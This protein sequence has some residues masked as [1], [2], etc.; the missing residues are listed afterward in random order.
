LP[1]LR[2]PKGAQADAI[3]ATV[4]SLR[5]EAATTV[6][7]EMGTGKS[8]IGVAAV[9]EAGFRRPLVVCPPQLP[10]KWVREVVTTIP[11]ARAVIVRSITDLECVR[12][13]P[14][15]FVATILSRER[16]KLGAAW[17]PA[18]L[19]LPGGGGADRQG[20]HIFDP[21]TRRALREQVIEQ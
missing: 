19:A 4:H 20:R 5:R 10:E 2:L 15:A 3:R 1:L 9:R 13:M 6:A 8:L 17:R 7:G 18:G 11:G 12:T 14:D 16:A 21:R